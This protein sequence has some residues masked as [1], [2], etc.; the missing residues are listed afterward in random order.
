MATE[1]KE[2]KQPKPLP[3]P[4]SDFYDVR[5]TLSTEEQDILKQ[6][7]EFAESKVAPIIGKYWLEDAF[8][9]ELLPGFKELNI[10]GISI[11]GYGGRGKSLALLGFIQ[12]ELARIDPSISTFFGVHAGLAMGSIYL[13]GSEEQKQKWPPPTISLEKIGCLALTEPLR[14]SGTTA[15][16]TT[17]SNLH[18][19]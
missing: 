12:M 19:G 9:F 17:T 14:A 15:R 16:L 2:I 8:P 13:G 6:V 4:N 10:G 11:K 3:A 1:R 18:R 5:S 7:R